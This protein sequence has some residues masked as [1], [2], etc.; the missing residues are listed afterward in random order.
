MA[1]S[2]KIIADSISPTGVRITTMEAVMHRFVLA[3]F[4]THRVFSRNSASSRAIPVEK[5]LEKVI[6]DPAFPVRWPCEQPG[7]QGGD[8]LNGKDLRDAVLLFSDLAARITSE[9]SA[10][11]ASHHDKSTRLH[12]SLLN[13]LLEPFMW[14]TVIVTSTE[15]NNFFHQRATEFS[16]LA[17]P[18]I[19]ITADLMLDAYRAS[20]PV[21]IDFGEW[22]LPYIDAET[23]GWA[24]THD[25]DKIEKNRMLRQISAARC[26]RV[27]YLTHDGKRDPAEDI[28]MHDRLI[29][30]VPMHASPLEHPATP[31]TMGEISEGNVAGNFYGWHQYRHHIKPHTFDITTVNSEEIVHEG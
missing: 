4:N 27:S 31:A 18:E 15:W 20:V 8:D 9:V 10:Y 5:Q 21:E 11:L 12:K 6:D 25:I 1:S 24:N 17:Q 28:A 30:A 22:H 7:M 23:I 29:S 3:E 16:P 14:H 19:A 2:A 13:R 26:A